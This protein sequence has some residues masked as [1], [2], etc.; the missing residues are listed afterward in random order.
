MLVICKYSFDPTLLDY[1]RFYVIG[2]YEHDQEILVGPRAPFPDGKNTPQ[3]KDGSA[4]IT[5]FHIYT[6]LKCLDGSRVIINRG[7]I[8]LQSKDQAARPETLNK[9]IVA[10]SGVAVST[11]EKVRRARLKKKS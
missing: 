8:Q 9:D 1:Q 6:P 3:A 2:N 10:I 4:G 7:W 11:P 5:G